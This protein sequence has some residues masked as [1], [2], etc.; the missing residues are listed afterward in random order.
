V[1]A[2]PKVPVD[3]RCAA[4]QAGSQLDKN[5]LSL[6]YKVERMK[7]MQNSYKRKARIAQ[8]I[9]RRMKSRLKQSQNQL[10]G[11]AVDAGQNDIQRENFVDMA[12][13]CLVEDISKTLFTILL[14]NDNKE[15]GEYEWDSGELTTAANIHQE[16]PGIYE[17]LREMFRLPPVE[18]LASV[19]PNGLP[20]ITR[21]TSSTA[22]SSMKSETDNSVSNVTAKSGAENTAKSKD[23]IDTKSESSESDD[24]D[25]LLTAT[26]VSTIIPPAPGTLT[27]R[28]VAKE[29]IRSVTP[30]SRVAVQRSAAVSQ[31]AVSSQANVVTEASVSSD[32]M[33][34][35]DHLMGEEPTPVTVEQEAQSEEQTPVT[36]GQE[37]LSE[38]S[39]ADLIQGMGDVHGSD[40][41]VY[42]EGGEIINITDP[43][44]L[45]QILE[46]SG[47]AANDGGNYVVY[48]TEEQ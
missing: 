16:N 39:V 24:I 18:A 20:N 31:P 12:K 35:G 37:L 7:M 44:V 33:A 23:I 41:I 47:V 15:E 4:V 45:Q 30:G 28:I 26:A 6:E 5:D 48:M 34:S 19:P 38:G 9:L 2:Q 36:V 25:R 32:D 11:Y 1:I 13:S 8:Q 21:T 10:L 40:V 17:F 14:R 46:Q 27:P 42:N 43:A 22:T 3:T 29:P